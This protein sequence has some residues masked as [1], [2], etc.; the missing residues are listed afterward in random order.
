MDDGVN[1]HQWRDDARARLLFLVLDAPPHYT[2]DRITRLQNIARAA[3]DRGVRIIPVAASGISKETE[4]L[5]R[6]LDI[7]TGGTYVFITGHSGIGGS[8]IEPTVGGYNVE[9]LNNLLVR[10]ITG[11]TTR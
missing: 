7:A 3:A 8:H 6:F 1:N 5:L 2:Q 4:F 11:Y 10:V 9:F